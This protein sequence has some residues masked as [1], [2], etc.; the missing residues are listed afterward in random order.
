M[1]TLLRRHLRLQTI[2]MF[3]AVIVSGGT[4]EWAHGG[5]DDPGCDPVPVHHDHAAHRVTAGPRGPEAPSEHC[6]LCHLLSSL[7]TARPAESLVT[8]AAASAASRRPS[9]GTF[10]IA[11]VAVAVPARAPP[12][13]LL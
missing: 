10:T 5:W 11:F 9:D 1:L 8:H 13:V 6:A 4:M 3:L 7:R 12:A 2:A